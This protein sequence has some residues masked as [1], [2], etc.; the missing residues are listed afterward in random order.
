[1]KYLVDHAE[2]GGWSPDTVQQG[3]LDIARR[4]DPEAYAEILE[5]LLS[6]PERTAEKWAAIE[7]H[8]EERPLE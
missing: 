3:A 2:D 7:S 6:D 1:M 8:S 4:A 5:G